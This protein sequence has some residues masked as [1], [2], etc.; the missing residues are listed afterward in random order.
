MPTKINAGAPRVQTTSREVRRISPALQV[1]PEV[2]LCLSAYHT[3]YTLAHRPTT[4]PG[5]NPA[6]NSLPTEALVIT[7][8][9]IMV[10]LGGMMMAIA[11]EEL[12][13]PSEKR[14]P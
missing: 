7:A 5:R 10:M 8:N 11:P 3:Q 2:I 12:I 4:M 1:R 9:R 13:N 14:S 6:R